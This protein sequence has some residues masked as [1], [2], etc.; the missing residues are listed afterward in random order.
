MR[1]VAVIISGVIFALTAGCNPH[2]ENIPA[3]SNVITSPHQAFNEVTLF[4]YEHGIK[5][6]Q[7]DTE[8]MRRPLADTGVM[9]AIPV[10]ISVY[11]SLGSL[12]ARILS[13]SGTSDSK[14]DVFDLW[15]SVHIKN[16]NGMTVRS[17]Q[18]RWFRGLRMVTSDTLVQMET[19]KGDILMGKGLNARDD[20]SRF[21][22][23]ADVQGVFPDFKRRIEEDDE[24]FFR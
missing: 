10:K 12:S 19:S 23:S 14:M 24:D 20:F 21:S 17:H 15:G 2:G 16:E 11:D 5:R 13:D 6:W 22:F 7:L 9:L 3:A 18:L 8:Y 4:F 1:I